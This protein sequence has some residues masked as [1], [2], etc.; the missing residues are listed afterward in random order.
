MNTNPPSKRLVGYALGAG[1][2]PDGLATGRGERGRSIPAAKAL[3]SRRVEARFGAPV[4]SGRRQND[5]QAQVGLP[6]AWVK[7][8]RLSLPHAR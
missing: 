6:G 5:L 2:R 3:Q 1:T 8:P 7:S 4:I